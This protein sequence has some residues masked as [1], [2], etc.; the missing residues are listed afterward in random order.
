MTHASFFL[1]QMDRNGYKMPRDLLDLFLK[2]SIAEDYFDSEKNKN[3]KIKK[4]SSDHNNIN[5]N[6]K[7]NEPAASFNKFD[8]SED[9]DFVY[10]RNKI[11]KFNK[12]QKNEII[13]SYT[14][15]I[16]I[17]HYRMEI[18]FV[19][20]INCITDVSCIRTIPHSI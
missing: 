8:N 1:S 2:V 5:N 16:Q 7:L 17:L 6:F 19:M 15:P 18:T 9:Q 3:R 13:N 11:D 14:Y 10:Y 20:V 4:K 12:K